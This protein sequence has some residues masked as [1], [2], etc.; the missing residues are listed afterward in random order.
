LFYRNDV[1]DSSNNPSL[2]EAP[3]LSR[4]DYSLALG[5]PI[6][7]NKVF[8]FGS[9]ERIHEDRVLNFTFPATGNAQ[10]DL[11]LRNF[12]A[13]FDNPSLTRETRGFF[14]VD[15]Q[16][17]RHRLSQ[18]VNYTNGVIKE[19]LP[20]S[21]ADSLPSRRNDTSGRSLLLGL[22]DTVMLGDQA[23]PWILN[24]RGGYRGDLANAWASAHCI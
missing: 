23:N 13:P 4:F 16:L 17:G 20:L 6:V 11:V 1:F 5:G 18:E 7:K 15:E 10:A 3:D 19:F 21:Q 22:A 24:L 12:E 8:F 14:K 2:P 9:A